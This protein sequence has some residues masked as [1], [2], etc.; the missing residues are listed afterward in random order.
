MHF[1]PLLWAMNPKQL[2]LP[3]MRT[4]ISL[5]KGATERQAAEPAS[6]D[7][8][9]QCFIAAQADWFRVVFWAWTNCSLCVSKQYLSCWYV[10]SCHKHPPT[11]FFIQNAVWKT[12]VVIIVGI[13]QLTCSG[14]VGGWRAGLAR[15]SRP[16]I[17]TH[18]TWTHIWTWEA[19]SD[20]VLP[21]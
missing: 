20:K 19:A 16:C 12:F 6:V 8:R 18:C 11:S 9:G 21:T 4:V 5:A 2:T 10:T 7:Y 17:R 13:F 3:S 14:A 1:L 15:K